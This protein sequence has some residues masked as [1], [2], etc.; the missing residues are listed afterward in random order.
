MINVQRQ[1]RKHHSGEQSDGKYR[2]ILDLK[3]KV[4][5]MDDAGVE[6]LHKNHLPLQ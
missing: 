2:F 4:K 3:V 6:M 1:N 5:Q